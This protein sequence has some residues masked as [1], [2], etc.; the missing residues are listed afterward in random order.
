[1]PDF[2]FDGATKIISEPLSTGDTTAEVGRDIYSAWKR[3]VA[4]G[5]GAGFLPAF[6]VEGGTPIGA[7]GLFTGATLI[8]TNGWKIRAADYDH[9]L[10]IL[11]NLFS[12]DGVVA[13]K[14]L[15]AS[16]TV[17]VS[18]SVAAQGIA[19]GSAMTPIQDQRLEELH[20]LRGLDSVNPVTV[21][22]TQE[23]AGDIALDISG[24]GETTSTLTR[25]P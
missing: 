3:W 17:F 20:R 5:D 8:L 22:A 16:A 4:L 10:T 15:T 13:V 24:D 14:A 9:Q 1:M 23:I 21:T 25:Q 11:G 19:T 12:D 2:L 18:A 6:A 7:T